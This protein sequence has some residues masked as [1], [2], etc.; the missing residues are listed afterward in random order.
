[1]LT[2]HARA[3]SLPSVSFS[4]WDK[5]N[6]PGADQVVP[7]ADLPESTD[8]SILRKLAVLKLNGGLGQCMNLNSTGSER[9]GDG[10][11]PPRDDYPDR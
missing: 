3:C 1:M 9:E 5:I 10:A 7:Y 8:G 2:S 6:P 11:H 4:V